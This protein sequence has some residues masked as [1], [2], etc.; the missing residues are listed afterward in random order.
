MREVIDYLWR[1]CKILQARGRDGDLA[2]RGTRTHVGRYWL[3]NA[4]VAK[5]GATLIALSTHGRSGFNRLVLG[6]VAEE[7]VPE[8]PGRDQA[9]EACESAGGP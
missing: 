2:M 9:L 3:A 1:P 7:V 4:V 6:S 8:G 5:V